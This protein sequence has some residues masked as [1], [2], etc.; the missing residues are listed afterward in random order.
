MTGK[1]WEY[2][3][4]Q[5]YYGEGYPIFEIFWHT[6][7]DTLYLHSVQQSSAIYPSFFKT[8]LDVRL[9][10]PDSTVDVRFFQDQPD[11]TFSAYIGQPVQNLI[12]D[13][14]AWL[15]KKASVLQKVD[16]SPEASIS[17]YPNPVRQ[18]FTIRTQHFQPGGLYR[19]YDL[20][21]KLLKEENIVEQQTDVVLDPRTGGNVF[22]LEVI[23]GKGIK[24]F[25]VKLIRL[26]N[27]L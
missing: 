9:I 18:I 10:L 4:D 2:F 25:R 24:P 8:S 23:S 5:W 7:N 11:Q 20:S 16:L 19:I 14:E 6:L 22:L 13:P 26:D 1:N 21:G 3:F 27:Y 12:F 17:V 15:L